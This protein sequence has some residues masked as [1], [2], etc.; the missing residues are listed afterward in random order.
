MFYFH[1]KS[2]HKIKSYQIPES[3]RTS[4][5]LSINHLLEL[6]EGENITSIIQVDNFDTNEFLLMCTKKG[7]IK[8]TELSSFSY[9][10]TRAIRAINL[11][12]EDEL[13]WVLQSNGEK[14]IILATSA[15]MVIRL[16]EIKYDLWDEH[17]EVYEPLKLKWMI[18]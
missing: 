2:L 7:I 13:S 6:D 14:H 9:F 16:D 3:S 8:K 1:R 12:D 4:K 5:G 18:I 17:L 15:G 10:K 11:D